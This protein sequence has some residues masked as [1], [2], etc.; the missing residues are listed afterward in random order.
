MLQIFN[1]FC[2]DDEWLLEFFRI[3]FTLT[4]FIDCS[5]L[6]KLIKKKSKEVVWLSLWHVRCAICQWIRAKQ[7]WMRSIAHSSIY[8]LRFVW[9]WAHQTHPFEC[10]W[11]H[12]FVSACLQSISIK[13]T[14]FGFFTSG[15]KRT[16]THIWRINS[17]WF[18]QLKN[19]FCNRRSREC[20]IW[21]E[22]EWNMM[23]T[24]LSDSN[25]HFHRL[26]YLI[27]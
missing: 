23:R 7:R 16:H 4:I 25:Q 24:V 13:W 11:V 17:N 5:A 8:R 12:A 6:M 2:V 20:V 22:I 14:G 15:C 18:L 21:N 3:F 10:V 26:L 27:V 9:A 19:C 1:E